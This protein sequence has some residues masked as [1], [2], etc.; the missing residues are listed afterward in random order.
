MN[1]LTQTVVLFSALS[2]EGWGGGGAGVYTYQ[3]LRLD[4]GP[5]SSSPLAVRA[6]TPDLLSPLPAPFGVHAQD[7]QA[8]N[9][10]ETVWS[11]SE[12]DKKKKF[13]DG[14]FTSLL[15][16]R[17]ETAWWKWGFWVPSSN[18]FRPRVATLSQK[19]LLDKR[20]ESF[21]FCSLS[22]DSSLC[23]GR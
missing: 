4:A 5:G 13:G 14:V 18:A 21:F 2:T 15:H 20:C 11:V 10:L 17:K 12:I 3:P 16:I 9:R 6:V 1:C 22:A 23:T 8:R 7:K 19:Y